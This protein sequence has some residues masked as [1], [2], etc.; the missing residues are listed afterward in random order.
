[1][2]NGS[3]PHNKWIAVFLLVL[4]GP[5][6]F[7][8]GCGKKGPPHPPRRP[9]PP[10]VQDLEYTIRNNIV[11]LS[12][13]IP[14]SENGKASPPAAVKVYRCQLS[15]EEVSCENCPIRYSLSGD[16]PIINKRSDKASPIRMNYSESVEPGYRY[17]YKVTLI[18]EY[19]I[20]GKDSN[21]VQFDLWSN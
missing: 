2:Q 20:G 21:V 14:G 16:I 6:F 13:T 3:C 12:W 10:A 15:P 9:L 4:A 8:I 18:D 19:G 7:W 5:G 1:M 11:E 17:L